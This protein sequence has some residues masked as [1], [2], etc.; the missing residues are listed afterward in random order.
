[1]GQL[2]YYGKVVIAWKKNSPYGPLLN[3]LYDF[4]KPQKYFIIPHFVN[5]IN[6][7]HESGVIE[8]IKLKYNLKEPTVRLGNWEHFLL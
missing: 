3:Y 8:N 6:K 7:M 4:L 5:S 1:M 2:L